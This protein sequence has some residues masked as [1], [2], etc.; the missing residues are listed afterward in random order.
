VQ[1]GIYTPISVASHANMNFSLCSATSKYYLGDF[2]YEI[3]GVYYYCLGESYVILSCILS[4]Y[5]L[6]SAAYLLRS[7][8]PKPKVI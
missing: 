1:R 4:V 8:T 6:R 2:F 5:L 3:I 7:L